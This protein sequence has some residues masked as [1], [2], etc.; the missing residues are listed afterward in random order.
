MVA[1]SWQ[2]IFKPLE[3]Q[4]W[5]GITFSVVGLV[6]AFLLPSL[7]LPSW[8][9]TES[10]ALV[11]RIEHN[12]ENLVRPVFRIDADEQDYAR[13][14]WSNRS[15]LA[16]GQKVTLVRNA[17]GSDWYLKADEEM[18]GIAWIVRILG[19]IFLLIGTVVLCLTIL[20]TPTYIVHTVGGAL[21]ALSFGIPATFALPGLLLAYRM[22]PNLFFSVN[23][24]LD[25][26]TWVLGSVFTLLGILTTI[27]TI[28]LARYQLRNRSLGWHWSWGNTDRQQ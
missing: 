23:D 2:Y 15:S 1:F 6:L 5:V 18:Q 8:Q 26:E 12:T 21:G 19:G 17:D 11:V 27:G 3:A 25:T 16:I 14:M 7:L 20:G 9:G 4:W 22:R 28:F 13:N 24:Q 10:P